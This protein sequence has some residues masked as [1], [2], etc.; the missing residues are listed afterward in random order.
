MSPGRAG[1]RCP[2][3]ADGIAAS[4]RHYGGCR[5]G[6]EASRGACLRCGSNGAYH[7]VDLSFFSRIQQRP[8]FDHAWNT[9]THRHMYGRY[10]IDRE[11]A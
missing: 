5:S 9:L 11:S 2:R 1:W 6:G 3:R 4:S 8:E 7:Y 10:R